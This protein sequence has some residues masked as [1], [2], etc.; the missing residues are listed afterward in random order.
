MRKHLLLITYLQI[1]SNETQFVKP[2][3]VIFSEYEVCDQKSKIKIYQTIRSVSDPNLRQFD[4]FI[5]R[6][7]WYYI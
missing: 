1:F 7:K 3:S 4:H 5:R 6:Y 2:E